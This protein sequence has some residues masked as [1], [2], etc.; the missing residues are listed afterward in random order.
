M[1]EKYQPIPHRLKNMAVGG[2]VAGAVDIIDDLKDK[3]QQT[4]NAEQD[5]V[6]QQTSV[7]ISDL[8]DDLENLEDLVNEKQMEI[9][10]TEF[11]IKPTSGSTHPVTSGGIYTH[12]IEAETVI[13][14]PTGD[15]NPTSAEAAYERFQGNL[16]L[17]QAEI[18][19]AQLEIGAVQTDL[20]PTEDSPN[21]LPSGAIY[22]LLQTLAVAGTVVDTVTD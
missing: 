7:D 10:A 18:N 17:M 9:G 5:V 13:G 6:N 14:D 3:D 4:I 20:V 11:D 22:N 21:M 8:S 1:T 15:W 2:H 12:N 19:A 16:D